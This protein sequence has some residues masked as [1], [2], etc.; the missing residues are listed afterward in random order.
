MGSNIKSSTS[1]NDS[2]TSSSNNELFD[3][4]AGTDTVIF[5]GKFSNYSFTRTSTSLDLDDQ[6]TSTN[7]G[8]DT[9]SNI[10]YI[11]F[12]DQTVEESKVDVVKTYNGNFSD[13]KFYNKG[14]SLIHI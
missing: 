4:G 14:L 9:L 8:T 10:E 12:T 3:G 7:D 6:R 11:Q 13:Y 5:T 1:G 2:L